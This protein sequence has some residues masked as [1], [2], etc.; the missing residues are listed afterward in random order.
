MSYWVNSNSGDYVSLDNRGKYILCLIARKLP[1]YIPSI[2]NY[3]GYLPEDRVEI[4]HSQFITLKGFVPIKGKKL[5]N[6]RHRREKIYAPTIKG[7]EKGESQ[8]ISMPLTQAECRDQ[9]LKE[10]GL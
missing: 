3:H 5:F 10:L 1:D 9:I 6:S 8:R 4:T 2:G 7:G